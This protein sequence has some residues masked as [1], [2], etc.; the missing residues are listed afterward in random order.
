[1]EEESPIVPVYKSSIRAVSDLIEELNASGKFNEI[2][3]HNFE[4]RGPEINLPRTTLMGLEAF[5]FD[6]NDGRWVIRFALSL[7]SYNDADLMNEVE[8]AAAIHKRFR[9]G[10][11]IPL[12]EMTNG[13]VRSEL[14][15]SIFRMLPM[16]QSELRNYRTF[17]IELARTGV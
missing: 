9:E 15:V 2:N 12:R 13:D 7:S 4:E 6:E 14:V 5:S 17:G 1:M 16:A 3:F 10:N 8:L 11:K